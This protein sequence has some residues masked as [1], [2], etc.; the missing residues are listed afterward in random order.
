ME[1][2]SAAIMVPPGAALSFT[3]VVVLPF[4]ANVPTLCGAVQVDLQA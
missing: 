1:I 4:I 2:T 3:K